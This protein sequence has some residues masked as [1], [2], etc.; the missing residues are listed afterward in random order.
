MLLKYFLILQSR[1]RLEAT[2]TL[3]RTRVNYVLITRLVQKEWPCVQLVTLA[4]NET[5]GELRVVRIVNKNRAEMIK[6]M[7]ILYRRA[8]MG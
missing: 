2:R 4:R 8:K 1:V 5:Q 3:I 7:Y 6:S